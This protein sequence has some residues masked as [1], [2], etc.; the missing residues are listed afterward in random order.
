MQADGPIR[1]DTAPSGTLDCASCHGHV[2]SG[3]AA[4]CPECRSLYHLGC[5]SAGSGCVVAGC[6]GR[7]AVSG[8]AVAVASRHTLAT[9]AA[10]PVKVPAPSIEL[11]P[12]ARYG[13]RSRERRRPGWLA[14]TAIAVAALAIGVAAALAFRHNG[15]ATHQENGYRSG[16]QAGYRA[17]TTGAFDN[18]FK[19]GNQAGWDAGYQ[20]GFQAACRAARGAGADCN[21]SIV[22]AGT[23]LSTAQ[24]GADGRAS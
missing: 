2:S 13:E 9:A 5:W 14:T 18:G 4:R 6:H 22:P 11:L 12:P 24:S 10:V 3:T 17:G 16:W 1:H 8:R 19:K 20:S 23:A 21:N 7:R 15:D